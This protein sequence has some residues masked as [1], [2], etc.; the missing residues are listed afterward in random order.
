MLSQ[1]WQRNNLMESNPRQYEAPGTREAS[2]RS[3]VSIPRS[4]LEVAS[5][6]AK[7]RTSHQDAQA[8]SELS[9][10]GKA[11]F[12]GRDHTN[13]VAGERHQRVPGIG[14]AACHLCERKLERHREG[15]FR[16]VRRAASSHRRT[17]NGGIGGTGGRARQRGQFGLRHLTRERDG[18]SALLSFPRKPGQSSD[19]RLTGC[20]LRRRARSWKPT[21]SCQTTSYVL[22]L[23]S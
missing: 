3:H 21:F 14:A 17:D 9:N 2:N 20:P 22:Y 15:R 4:R 16:L 23:F 8:L 13:P 12:L 1:T 10:A 11:V 7:R 18:R 6:P 19:E 5:S